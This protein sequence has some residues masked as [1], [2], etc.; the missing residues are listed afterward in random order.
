M[1]ILFYRLAYNKS[2]LAEPTCLENS[3][4]SFQEA[5]DKSG[6]GTVNSK[7][8]DLAS[9]SRPE[10]LFNVSRFR[11]AGDKLNN[12]VQTLMIVITM[13]RS[14]TIPVHQKDSMNMVH[15]CRCDGSCQAVLHY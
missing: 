1:S 9:I 3:F 6:T 12:T 4:P 5:P 2:S 7:T 8:W 11:P 14:L 15:S 10:T 13:K